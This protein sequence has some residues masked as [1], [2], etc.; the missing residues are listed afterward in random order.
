M[1]KRRFLPFLFIISLIACCIEVDISVPSF[2]DM[3]DYFDVSEGI[4]QLTIAFN[5]IG[6]SIASFIYG[7]LSECYGRRKVMIIGNALL[8][9]GALGCVIA[10]T[11]AWLLFTRFIQGVGASTSAVVV[12]AMIAD[13]YQGHKAVTLISI[14][15]TCLTILI[16]IAP[17]A[18]GF[19]NE[20]IGWRGNYGVVAIICMISWS[21]LYCLLPETNNQ[22]KQFQIKSIISDYKRLFNC[23]TFLAAAIVPSL[24]YSAYMTFVGSASFLYMN[25]FGMKTFE[26]TLHQGAIIT[27]FSIMSFFASKIIKKYGTKKCTILFTSIYFTSISLF[28]IASFIY[29]LS[30][31]FITAFL[32]LFS[33]GNAICYSIIFT[34]SLEIFPDIKGTAS[35]AIMGMRALL[36]GLLIGL[37]SYLYNG[38]PS[39]VAVVMCLAVV[40]GLML[41]IHL[42]KTEKFQIN[43][44]CRN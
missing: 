43:E 19:I 35:S 9:A 3:S 10:P 8:M 27:F 40:L 29:S 22:T 36:C 2:P 5:F 25:H 18:G 11:M 24:L 31:Y 15:N 32:I 34:F 14:M 12:F 13:T 44:K 7:P 17:I 26:Y 41:T 33:L 6:F 21:L 30:A 4:I 28:T 42:I 23:S 38:D 20:S 1:A 16:S 37:T 39:R